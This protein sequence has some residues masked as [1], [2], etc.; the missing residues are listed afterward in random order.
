[1]RPDEAIKPVMETGRQPTR[2]SSEA[3]ER[4]TV[5]AL[6][7]SRFNKPAAIGTSLIVAPNPGPPNRS[8]PG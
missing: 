5:M 4:E 3:T 2:R 6:G 1:M 7:S 8:V